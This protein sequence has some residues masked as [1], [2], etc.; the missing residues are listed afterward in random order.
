[1]L[2]FIVTFRLLCKLVVFDSSCF[3]GVFNSESS[4]VATCE[5]W[6]NFYQLLNGASNFILAHIAV[7]G[8]CIAVDQ[9]I[10][11]AMSFHIACH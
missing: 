9:K 10:C 11:H 4:L 3:P 6:G 1:M 7:A 8:F 5:K 2:P